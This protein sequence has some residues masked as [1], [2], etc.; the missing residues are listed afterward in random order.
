MIMNLISVN[1]VFKIKSWKVVDVKKFNCLYCT[2]FE[3]LQITK[4][5]S[6]NYP[7]SHI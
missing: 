1:S 4:K 5:T 6:L 7:R 3:L 2:V